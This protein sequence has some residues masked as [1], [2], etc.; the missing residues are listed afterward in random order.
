M[1]RFPDYSLCIRAHDN[2][3][4]HGF[5]D[6]ERDYIED[7]FENLLEEFEEAREI[8]ESGERSVDEVYYTEQK[9]GSKKLEGVPTELADIIILILDY[10]GGKNIDEETYNELIKKSEKVRE[11][12]RRN[13]QR[14]GIQNSEEV[15][16]REVMEE[17]LNIMARSM[18]K[19]MLLYNPRDMSAVEITRI[20]ELL[21]IVQYMSVYAEY[22]GINIEE[23]T[24]EKME[25][26]EKRPLKYKKGEQERTIGGKEINSRTLLIRKLS[27]IL[28]RMSADPNIDPEELKKIAK[29]IEEI[30]GKMAIGSLEGDTQRKTGGVS[31]GDDD[32]GR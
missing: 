23:R 5:W 16:F 19:P 30:A 29:R 4:K 28:V 32:G 7:F 1:K 27:E 14:V 22:Y 21:K 3:V 17:C 18:I 6:R 9:D 13:I 10:I 12:Y 20:N 24:I 26:N 11:E 25:Y 8:L 2:A 15:I 31:P